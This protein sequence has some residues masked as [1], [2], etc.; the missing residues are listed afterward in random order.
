M[1]LRAFRAALEEKPKS[2]S[3]ERLLGFGSKAGPVET[4]WADGR[5]ASISVTRENE[6][7]ASVS[8]R[9][10]WPHNEGKRMLT[11]SMTCCLTEPQ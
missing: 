2:M 5:G 3:M 11:A 9:S 6:Q 8:N 4:D 10:G 1:A 7:R